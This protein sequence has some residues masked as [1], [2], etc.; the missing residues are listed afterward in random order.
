[1]LSVAN[2]TVVFS[3]IPQ[4]TWR[5][6][7]G[8]RRSQQHLARLQAQL[9]GVVV[10]EKFGFCESSRQWRDTKDGWGKLRKHSLLCQPLLCS[11]SEGGICGG[12]MVGVQLCCSAPRRI[13]LLQLHQLLPWKP[14]G[15]P[16]S[17]SA[18]VQQKR[19]ARIV[20][21]RCINFSS[22]TFAFVE[23]PF[24]FALL[25]PFHAKFLHREIVIQFENIVAHWGK[26][27]NCTSKTNFI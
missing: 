1:M 4:Q 25:F 16:R 12:G 20:E 24:E 7:A 6:P 17:S 3:P 8:F 21:N 14:A 5:K 18:V 15:R 13:A 11:K 9:A 10:L 27:Y 22:L 2:A 26:L 23:K 19:S